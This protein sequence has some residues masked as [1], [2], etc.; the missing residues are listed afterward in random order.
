MGGGVP[1]GL[2]A[3]ILP[4]PELA[5]AAPARGLACCAP[6]DPPA[7]SAGESPRSDNI[8]RRFMC[9]PRF[10]VPPSGNSDRWNG[11]FIAPS[12]A[13]LQSKPLRAMAGAEVF[14][15]RFGV[16]LFAGEVQGPEAVALDHLDVSVMTLGGSDLAI[17][18]EERSVEQLRERHVDSIIRR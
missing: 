17:A 18:S 3:V 12:C 6:A 8:L 13:R 4:A 11:P 9:T 5:L 7:S 1:F 16:A 15:V 10:E 14:E 2:S